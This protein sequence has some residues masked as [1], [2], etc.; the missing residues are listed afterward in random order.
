MHAEVALAAGEA[1]GV[2][3]GRRE[4][5]ARRFLAFR[6]GDRGRAARF[7]V[8]LAD[9]A[10]RDGEV[11]E[12][13]ELS[14]ERLVGEALEPLEVGLAV[15]EFAELVDLAEDLAFRVSG[16]VQLA[17]EL[18]DELVVA[19]G[20]DDDLALQR[21][22]DGRGGVSGTGRVTGGGGRGAG[23]VLHFENS[24]RR[25]KPRPKRPA[26][27][28]DPKRPAEYSLNCAERQPFLQADSDAFSHLLHLLF[29]L[30]SCLF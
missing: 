19:R 4:T 3:V 26:T 6:L 25:R 5:S 23:D 1:A 7:V 10:G 21:G 11:A 29:C 2:L 28:E 12:G 17:G 30:L 8:E 22:A 14:R 27:R 18:A 16:R 24:S 9:A 15:R 20:A 13:R